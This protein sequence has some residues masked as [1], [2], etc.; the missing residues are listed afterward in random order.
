MSK[1]LRSQLMRATISTFEDLGFVLPTPDVD[2]HQAA[3]ALAWRARV[4]FRGPVSGWLE[5]RITDAV[6]DEVAANMLGITDGVEPAVKRDALG[7]IANVVC[8]NVVPALGTPEDVFDLNAP[9]VR[10]IESG[11][12]RFG[13]EGALVLSIGLEAGRAELELFVEGMPAEE[14]A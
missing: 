7:E 3:I 11:A 1:Q 8:G 9:E 10:A 4:S 6:A 2:E 5:V 14:A 13:S 12:T